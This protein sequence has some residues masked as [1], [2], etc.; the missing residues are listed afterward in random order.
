[1][2]DLTLLGRLYQLQHQHQNRG[3]DCKEPTMADDD[4]DDSSSVHLLESNLIAS[5][6][7]LRAIPV[8]RV[9]TGVFLR[10]FMAWTATLFATVSLP[11]FISSEGALATPCLILM[12]AGIITLALCYGFMVHSRRYR[13][14]PIMHF[15]VVL[16]IAIGVVC[17][18]SAILIHQL[19][20]MCFVLM[21]WA[22][23]LVLLIKL[24]HKPHQIDAA[25]HLMLMTLY[26]SVLV[27]FVC[28]AQELTFKDAGV[29][30][31]A[32]CLNLLVIFFRYDWLA[33]HALKP[34]T[35]YSLNDTDNAWFDLYTW[36]TEQRI[37]EKC[38]PEKPSSSSSLPNPYENETL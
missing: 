26:S 1:M 28:A 3:K 5:D 8:V 6:A 2:E 10:E 7:E 33:N 32:F 29:N 22:G 38:R 16:H 34:G 15:M 4:H 19:A 12:V 18:C 37:T 36:T 13:H 31:L 11:L 25:D 9:L 24:N 17:V 14:P 21:V 23:A 27:C 35:N 20:T 30:T